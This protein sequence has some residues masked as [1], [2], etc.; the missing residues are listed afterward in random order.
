MRDRA[1]NV[2]GINHNVDNERYKCRACGEVSDYW[3]VE[4]QVWEQSG[5]EDGYICKACFEKVIP[6]PTY[7]S[8]NQWWATKTVAE[9]KSKRRLISKL[10][11]LQ[12]KL[13]LDAEMEAIVTISKLLQ[14]ITWV[15]DLNAHDRR[16]EEFKKI[17]TSDLKQILKEYP[18]KL[19]RMESDILD[20]TGIEYTPEFLKVES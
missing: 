8:H 5:F 7:L 3:M 12:Y 6:N 2:W 13:L 1:G 14:G 9:R 10:T 4:N 17:P 15:A 20:C 11:K 18:D 16:L 19:D